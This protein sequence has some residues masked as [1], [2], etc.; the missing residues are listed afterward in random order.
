MVI[1]YIYKCKNGHHFINDEICPYCNEP[2]EKKIEYQRGDCIFCGQ[3][4]P[5]YAYGCNHP[6]PIEVKLSDGPISN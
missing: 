5:N 4:C 2:F 3:L 1:A 6:N